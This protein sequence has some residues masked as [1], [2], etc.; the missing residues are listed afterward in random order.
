M[1]ELKVGE[2]KHKVGEKRR[3]LTIVKTMAKKRNGFEQWTLSLS[4]RSIVAQ[5]RH[6]E[7]EK[8][9]NAARQR[10]PVTTIKKLF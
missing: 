6:F 2:R 7:K 10:K 8:K 4:L 1:S 5:K 3:C 9:N